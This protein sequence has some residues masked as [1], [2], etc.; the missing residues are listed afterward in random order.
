MKS[1]TINIATLLILLL[2][3]C[4]SIESSTSV[5]TPPVSEVKSEPAAGGLPVKDQ[6]RLVTTCYAHR[7]VMG[8]DGEIAQWKAKCRVEVWAGDSQSPPEL[9]ELTT[10]QRDKVIKNIDLGGTTASP[11]A[12]GME[13]PDQIAEKSRYLVNEAE[14]RHYICMEAKRTVLAK[15]KEL[16]PAGYNSCEKVQEVMHNLQLTPEL[17]AFINLVS[18]EMKDTV[19]LIHSIEQDTQLSQ[20]QKSE[21][22]R[23]AKVKLTGLLDEQCK[24]DHPSIRYQNVGY[25]PPVDI[26]QAKTTLII[27]QGDPNHRVEVVHWPPGSNYSPHYERLRM[28]VDAA[29]H[30]AVVTNKAAG[31]YDA[32]LQPVD[33]RRVDEASVISLVKQ[34]EQQAKTVPASDSITSAL[35]S[36]NPPP[37][38]TLSNSS[39]GDPIQSLDEK[40]DVEQVDA[41]YVIPNVFSG[42]IY[43]RFWQGIVE[44]NQAYTDKIT[45]IQN[46]KSIPNDVLRSTLQSNAKER[47]SFIKNILINDLLK[48]ETLKDTLLVKDDTSTKKEWKKSFDELNEEAKNIERK[49]LKSKSILKKAKDYAATT[50]TWSE[51]LSLTKSLP[52]L[53]Y[54]EAKAKIKAERKKS[55]MDFEKKAYKNGDSTGNTTSVAT[56]PADPRTKITLQNV[57]EPFRL[58]NASL[59]GFFSSISPMKGVTFTNMFGSKSS[60]T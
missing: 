18:G 16:L 51:R 14:A 48:E 47:F 56:V 5:D 41:E 54:E 35:D 49:Y 33:R 32:F 60:D 55:R 19:A 45:A 4:G 36:S 30:H 22:L 13:S 34:P 9:K 28:I 37:S 26:D 50:K 43:A 25:L 20:H 10:E 53:I 39:S 42:D 7:A 6:Q 29:A 44:A 46:N 59:G 21:Q 31:V 57:K 2:S 1:S 8:H 11:A 27:S 58:A 38:D 24:D 23:A 52:E 17:E 3:R 40:I 12:S 15:L